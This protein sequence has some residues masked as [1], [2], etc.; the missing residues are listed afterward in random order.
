MSE[1]LVERRSIARDPSIRVDYVVVDPKQSVLHLLHTLMGPFTSNELKNML[2]AAFSPLQG[3]YV[4]DLSKEEK[5]VLDRAVGT[6]NS[7]FIQMA[8]DNKL[9]SATWSPEFQKAVEHKRDKAR[10]FSTS[11]ARKI[12]VLVTTGLLFRLDTVTS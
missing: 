6:R 4:A 5:K 1:V 8:L 12:A 2:V 9:S 3:K 10:H 7:E 11:D